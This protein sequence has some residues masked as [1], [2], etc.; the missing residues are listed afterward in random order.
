MT[1]RHESKDAAQ[2]MS[3]TSPA[4]H[5]T[6]IMHPM[7][8]TESVAPP[9]VVDSDPLHL[10]STGAGVTTPSTNTSA[11]AIS[12]NSA[13]ATSSTSDNL[14]SQQTISTPA[15]HSSTYGFICIILRH[16]FGT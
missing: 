9:L 8:Q 2:V 13:F 12:A 7:L 14:P 15:K 1:T 11:S 6:Y 3:S 10:H 16:S 5:S 4:P